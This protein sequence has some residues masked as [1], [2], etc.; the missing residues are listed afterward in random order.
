MCGGM[1]VGPEDYGAGEEKMLNRIKELEG[2]E[3]VMC[4]ACKGLGHN[5]IVPVFLGAAYTPCPACGAIGLMTTEEFES[6]P[7]SDREKAA[8][9]MLGF[10]RKFNGIQ[11]ALIFGAMIFALG[12][13]VVFSAILII[14]AWL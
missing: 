12:S 8:N 10:Y 4:P 2:R 3:T 1:C 5:P 11:F 9:K 14:R 7:G 6:Y 13:L